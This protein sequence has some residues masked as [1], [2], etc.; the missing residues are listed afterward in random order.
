MTSD[1]DEGLWL[2]NADN[3][4]SLVARVGNTGPNG[5]QFSSLGQAI[6]FDDGTLSFSTRIRAGEQ[7]ITGRH[8]WS[9]D[10]DGELNSIAIQQGE[11]TP[12]GVGIITRVENHF[13]SESGRNA[14]V[15]EIDGDGASD[16]LY[17]QNELGEFELVAYSGQE[18]EVQLGDFR[19]ISGVGRV[20]FHNDMMVMRL[21]F[22]N[23]SF[24]FFRTVPEPNASI[25]WLV[26]AWVIYAKRRTCFSPTKM[27][28]QHG[29]TT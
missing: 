19:T 7:G 5:T 10:N 16:R 1:N 18:I 15:A 23:G 22:A 29:D 13:L 24:G 9:L 3:S 27:K 11:P 12:D 2:S 17:Y 14:F 21:G 6:S 25:F 26:I 20:T 28:G 8:L 4:I